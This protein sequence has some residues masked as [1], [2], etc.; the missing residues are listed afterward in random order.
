MFS[1]VDPAILASLLEEEKIVLLDGAGRAVERDHQEG[2]IHLLGPRPLPRRV[3]QADV[4]F[5]WYP[6]AKRTQLEQVL[7]L[8]KRLQRGEVEGLRELLTAQMTVNS[9]IVYGDL[10]RAEAPLI[11]V[12]SCCVTG[13]I[14][15][16]LR[17]ECGPQLEQA[18]ARIV[19]EGCGA[20]VYMSGHE[21][22]GIGLWAKAVT[23]LLQDMGHDT[24]DANRALNLPEDSRDFTDAAL[25]LRHFLGDEAKVRLLSNNPNKRAALEQNG[26]EVAA[27]ER[28]LTGVSTHNLRYLK[29]KRDRGHTLGDLPED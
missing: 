7:G 28:T 18:F 26:V 10:G 3:D 19:D 16:S 11:R 9:L 12:H 2:R 15:G 29:A 4:A 1:Y 5:A 24:Y 27:V 14:F 22:R 23:Y 6:F 20:I 13:E 25:V 8:G 21:G 17:C